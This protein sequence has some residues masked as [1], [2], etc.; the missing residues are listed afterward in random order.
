M[1]HTGY[2]NNSWLLRIISGGRDGIRVWAGAA[3]D[4]IVVIKSGGPR[5]GT[6]CMDLDPGTIV[7]SSF[8][9][10]ISLYSF[11]VAE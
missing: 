11:N 1:L 8:D 3:Y 6:I 2:G 10:T 4:C 5:L 7:S 9:K